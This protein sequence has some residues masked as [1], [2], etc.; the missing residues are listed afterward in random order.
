MNKKFVLGALSILAFTTSLI[1]INFAS[2]ESFLT[3]H[4]GSQLEGG[5]APLLVED[6]TYPV[7]SLL[8]ANGWSAH[9][10][11]GT[12]PITVTSPGLTFNGY[13]SSGVGNAVSL[14]TSGEDVNRP[15]AAQTTGMVYAAFM[16]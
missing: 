3:Q 5:A 12:N 7:G 9:S 11:A 14:T 13:P 15:F 16:V 10:G 2:A 4:S 1:F 8:T 6:F